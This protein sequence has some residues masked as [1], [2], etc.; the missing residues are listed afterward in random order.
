MKNDLNPNQLNN[1]KQTCSKLGIS[2]TTF[3]QLVLS[4]RLKVVRIGP[5]M[6]RVAESEIERIIANG[7]L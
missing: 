2:R 4:G 7:G 6:T 3:Y 5:R 1:V